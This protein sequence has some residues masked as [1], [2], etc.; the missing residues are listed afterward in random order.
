MKK[1]TFTLFAAA[2]VLLAMCACSTGPRP[3]KLFNGKDLEGWGAVLQ[4]KSLDPATEFTVRDGVIHLSGKFG[5]I[6]PKTVYS[7]Y[8]LEAEWRWAGEASNSGIFVHVT[9]DDRWLPECFECQL[10][11]GNAGSIYGFNGPTSAEMRAA[12]NNNIQRREPNN[13]KPVGEWNKAEIV[14]DGDNISITINGELQVE[15]T[16]VTPSSGYIGLQ[17]EGEAV[18]FRNVVLTPLK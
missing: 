2:A 4:D 14:C 5:Y 7:D 15:A 11:A 6:Y 8:K 12:G 1:T 17:S 18:E 13:E 16:G 3:I 10:R 9:P